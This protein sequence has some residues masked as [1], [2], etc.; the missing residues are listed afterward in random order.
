[1]KKLIIILLILVLIPGCKSKED[2]AKL[3]SY[4][5]K[6]TCKYTYEDE[7]DGDINESDSIIYVDYDE[8]DNVIAAIY[9]SISSL[10]NY[11]D[12]LLG[13]L[14]AIIHLYNSMSGIKASKYIVGESLVFEIMYEYEKID[15]NEFRENLGDLIDEESMFATV[16]SLPIKLSE[17]E[18]LELKDYECEVK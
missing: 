1:M 16:K 6:M 7:L 13:S 15:L 4:D 18:S 11:N 5:T 17:F 9:Q 3:N 10:D 14:D 12:Y 2:E 8:E